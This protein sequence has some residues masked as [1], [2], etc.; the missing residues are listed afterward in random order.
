M[1]NDLVRNLLLK[2]CTQNFHFYFF[3]PTHMI[4]NF[5]YKR[6]TKWV[7]RLHFF[8]SLGLCRL[9]GAG[10]DT[11]IITPLMDFVRHK[12]AT[13]G[14]RVF[15]LMIFDML[16]TL[17][18]LFGFPLSFYMHFYECVCVCLFVCTCGDDSWCICS[19]CNG[20]GNIGPMRL[21]PKVTTRANR[22]NTSTSSIWP[23]SDPRHTRRDTPPAPQLR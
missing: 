5:R 6:Y 3:L 18:L 8:Y 10:K 21:K 9:A 2:I 22:P 4:L 16:N 19:L 7:R 20:R 14:P 13:K 11:P 1:P 23:K 15:L 12:R 17:I